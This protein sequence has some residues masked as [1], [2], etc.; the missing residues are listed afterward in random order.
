MR[1][2][3]AGGSRTLLV[4]EGEQGSQCTAVQVLP[5]SQVSELQCMVLPQVHGTGAQ[6]PTS[7]PPQSH[8]T[9]PTR[10]HPARVREGERHPSAAGDPRSRTERRDRTG[11]LAPNEA[12]GLP[13]PHPS[14]SGGRA[15][16]SPGFIKKGDLECLDVSVSVHLREKDCLATSPHLGRVPGH[17]HLQQAHAERPQPGLHQA[18]ALPPTETSSGAWLVRV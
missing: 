11:G 4:R 16:Q 2:K 7:Q 6:P 14:T 13:R 15:A 8:T 10:C 18:S 12:Q 3:K 1:T 9:P 5:K 17:H